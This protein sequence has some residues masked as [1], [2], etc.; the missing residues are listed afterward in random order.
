MNILPH[1]NVLS[2]SNSLEKPI[3]V[4]PDVFK[5]A[6]RHRIIGNNYCQFATLLV[7]QHGVNL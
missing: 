7:I 5:V 3:D 4:I 2:N 6:A 1:F